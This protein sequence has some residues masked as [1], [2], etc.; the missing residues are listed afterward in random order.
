MS[1]IRTQ[2]LLIRLTDP[3]PVTVLA[4]EAFFI[5]INYEWFPKFRKDDPLEYSASLLDMPD[6][7]NWMFSHP[8][9][10]SNAFLYGSAEEAGNVKIEVR[11]SYCDVRRCWDQWIP[12][13]SFIQR[14]GSGRPQQ[15]SHR[16]ERYIVINHVYSQLLHRPPSRR[17]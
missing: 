11:G 8:T 13:M 2:Y 5:P 10:N 9:N 3:K 1:W 4:T 16:E 15:T 6:L 12:E 17:R 7:P 14:P